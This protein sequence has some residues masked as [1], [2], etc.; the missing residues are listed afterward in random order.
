[1]LRSPDGWVEAI[2]IDDAVAIHDKLASPI[3]KEESS[4]CPRNASR[5]YVYTLED[6]PEELI[7]CLALSSGLV[8]V[9]LQL[10][11]LLRLCQTTP[12]SLESTQLVLLWSLYDVKCK[13]QLNVKLTFETAK[14]LMLR[15]T[16]DDY[17]NPTLMHKF[18]AASPSWRLT[19]GERT[20]PA[21]TGPAPHTVPANRGVAKSGVPQF[22]A[23]RLPA[24]LQTRTTN[25]PS[26][27]LCPQSAAFAPHFTVFTRMK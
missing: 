19:H 9:E 20:V 23:S 2:Q 11:I 4:Q 15:D 12:S 22:Q 18:T 14:L 5:M 26:S 8:H 7:S 27:L 6:G 21:A 10:E 1:M 25:C 17:Q 24:K 3:I 13:F 16:D